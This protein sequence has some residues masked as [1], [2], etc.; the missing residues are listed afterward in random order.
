MIN[1]NCMRGQSCKQRLSWRAKKAAMII[2]PEVARPR[3]D[4][5]Y[6]SLG[7]N[8]NWEV[9]TNGPLQGLPNRENRVC[10]GP[11]LHRSAGSSKLRACQ[12][13]PD[14]GP[15]MPGACV[16]WPPADVNQS[17]NTY[18]HNPLPS[19]AVFIY[20][21]PPRI[22]RRGFTASPFSQQ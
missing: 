1:I 18:A 19:C 21:I 22:S 10:K 8:Q 14:H 9:A 2:D 16:R 11:A 12:D 6:G 3:C 7:Q 17:G 15:G 5:Q 13:N 4:S 20:I